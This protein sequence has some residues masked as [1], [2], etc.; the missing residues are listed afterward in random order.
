MAK[1]GVIT[2]VISPEA[3]KQVDALVKSL[4]MAVE[5]AGKVNQAG[6]GIKGAGNL[7]QQ[8][9]DQANLTKL[10]KEY[11]SV[12]QKQTEAESKLAVEIEKER[13]KLAETK[14]AIKDKVREEKVAVDSITR[15]EIEIRKMQKA[16][17][18]LSKSEREANKAM[19][20]QIKTMRD[21]VRELRTGVGDMKANVG[22]YRQ[23][24]EGMNVSGVKS[25][26]I[27]QNFSKT[28]NEGS[29]NVGKMEVTLTGLKQTLA[30]MPGPVGEVSSVLERLGGQLKLG[31]IGLGLMALSATIYGITKAVELWRAKQDEIAAQNIAIIQTLT[32]YR[33]RVEEL[34]DKQKAYND[35]LYRTQVQN[36]VLTGKITQ[37]EAD[38]R[39]MAKEASGEANDAALRYAA[40]LQRQQKALKDV[41]DIQAGRRGG[42][43]E[44]ASKLL[45]AANDELA[46]AKENYNTLF[47]T[48]QLKQENASIS[49]T[50]TVSINKETTALKD[51]NEEYERQLDIIDRMLGEGRYSQIGTMQPKEAGALNTGVGARKITAVKQG[52]FPSEVTGE[53]YKDLVNQDISE[54]QRLWITR[55]SIAQEYTG[56]INDLVSGMYELRFKEIDEETRKDEE[57]RQREIELADGNARKIDEINTFYD[58]KAKDRDKERRKLEVEQAKYNKI[59]GILQSIINTALAV[60]GSLAQV[61]TLGPAA[62]VLAA[63]AGSIGAAQ[64]ALIAAQPIPA[65]AEGRKGGKAEFARINERGQEMVVTSTGDA[66]LPSGNFAYLPEGSSVIPHH[67]LVEMAGKA[68]TY[69]LPRYTSTDTGIRQEINGLHAGFRMLAS[70]IRNKKEAHIN[71]DRHGFSVMQKTGENYVKWVN[72]KVRL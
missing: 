53:D 59:A 9:Q 28:F 4:D 30:T 61:V 5:L 3:Q 31:V 25:S 65:Y 35:E 45:V 63:L 13:Q 70:E 7:Q 60:S 34:R 51:Q 46:T 18:S 32:N 8:S 17:D 44:M 6:A 55:L 29:Q 68:S 1:A 26:T 40:A 57:A 52:E 67:D 38:R 21:S 49:E 42:S 56:K 72:N 37:A 66:Y 64:T 23:S 24:L 48:N 27:I 58:K 14:Q 22:N 50:Q 36:L 39:I 10:Q 54:E 41:Q 2:E 47:R 71:I 12:L 19:A 11:L 33:K 16:Y 20:D 62:F 69:P 15:M 43:L